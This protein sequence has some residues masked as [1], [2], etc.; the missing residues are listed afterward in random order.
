MTSDELREDLLVLEKM[1]L[2][3]KI[4]L[5]S[6]GKTIWKAFSKAIKAPDSSMNDVL[7]LFYSHN[8]QLLWNRFSKLIFIRNLEA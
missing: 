7:D 6:S 3:Q 2:I 4:Q 1:G 8:L 5:E